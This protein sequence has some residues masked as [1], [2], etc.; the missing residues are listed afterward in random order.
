MHSLII[1]CAKYLIY[2]VAAF[3]VLF[4]LSLTRQRKIELAVGVIVSLIIATILAKIAAKLYYDPRPFVKSGVKPLFTHPADNGFPSDHT[5][6][7]A[8]VA[9]L[10][11][12]Y[13]KQLGVL[14]L[15]MSVLIGTARVAAHV[16]SPIDI[17]AGLLIG[18]IGAAAGYWLAKRYAGQPDLG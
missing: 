18:I 15:V 14:L 5:Y 3:A 16:H 13:H 9:A 10:L 7:S 8:T 12:F 6:L 1:F 4:W 11:F 17:V 2:I